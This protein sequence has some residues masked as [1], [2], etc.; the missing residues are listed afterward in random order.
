MIIKWL[1]SQGYNTIDESY[2]T[3]IRLWGMWYKGRVPSVHNYLQYN[4]AQKVKRCRKTLGMAKRICEDWA[5]LLLNEKV[6]ITAS[7]EVVNEIVGA[8][9][10][11]NKFGVYGNQLIEKAFAF[12]TGAFVEYVDGGNIIDYIT[13]LNIYPLTWDNGDITECAFAS[14]RKEGD[15]KYYYINIHR[16]D[17]A[18]L[19]VIENHLLKCGKGK[20]SVTEVDLPE[21]LE[22]E[23]QTGSPV[24]RFQIIYP[25]IA[26]NIDLDS[27]LGVS[28]YANALDQLECCDVIFD[29]F[30]NEYNLGRKRIMIPMSMARIMLQKD[31]ETI[32][33]FDENDLCFYAFQTDEKGQKIEEM[34]G[35]LRT[36]AH[37]EGLSQAINLTAYKCGLGENKYKFDRSA[38]VK[39][40]TEVISEDSE[41]FRSVRKHEAII[42]TAITGLYKALADM[43]GL[44]TD[45]DVNIDFDD[46]IIQDTDAEQNRDRQDVLDGLMSKVE[47]RQKWYGETAEQAEMAVAGIRSMDA[48]MGF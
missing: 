33:V 17:D 18:G 38:G 30:F 6:T 3:F 27:P 13:A 40:A 36:Q 26:N 32:P 45:F 7:D 44:G 25:N 35:E 20:T 2:R 14:E 37:T 9:L 19:Y 22:R 42:A 21:G 41:M 1:K 29:S 28:V 34:N 5:N 15:D 23:V 10:E 11:R 48:I 46:S 39:T 8:D 12:G 43:N 16:L 31:G 4:G 24:P 47:Y